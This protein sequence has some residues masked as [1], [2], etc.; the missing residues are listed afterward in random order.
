MQDTQQNEPDNFSTGRI[1]LAWEAP[2]YIYQEK[3]TDWYWWVGLAAI[4][5]LGFAIWQGSFLFGVLVL[6][7]WFTILLFAAKRPRTLKF[8]ISEQGVLVENTFYPWQH[9][10]SFWIFY[11][12]PIHKEISFESKKTLMLHLK[13]PLGDTDPQRAQEILKKYLPEIE[14]DDS[15]IDNLARLA[16]F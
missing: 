14:Q 1:I 7:G 4:V 2:E 12:P 9:L 6:I 11:T 10:K 3:G 16:K 13:V 15:L 8:S 5:F